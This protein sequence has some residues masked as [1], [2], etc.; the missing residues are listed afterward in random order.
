MHSIHLIN[1]SKDVLPLSTYNFLSNGP[2]FI[3]NIINFLKFA[4]KLN[5]DFEDFFHRL[6]INF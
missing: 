4:S 2:K 6:R 5:V 1:T 3:P